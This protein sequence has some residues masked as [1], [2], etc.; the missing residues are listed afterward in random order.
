MSDQANRTDNSALEYVWG[1]YRVYAA[2]SRKQKSKLSK[3][4]AAFLSLTCLGA[5]L[6]GVSQ[7]LTGLHISWLPRVAGGLS[8]VALAIAAYLGREALT[9]DRERHWIR[10]RSAAEA[11]K[12]NAYLYITGTPPYNNGKDADD[13]ILKK[14][15]DLEGKISD[16]TAES[17]D[18]EKKRERIPSCPISVEDYIEKRVKDQI[19]FY[20]RRAAEHDKYLSLWSSIRLILGVISVALGVLIGAGSSKLIGV[21]IAVISTAVSTIVAHLYAGRYSYLVLSYQSASRRLGRLLA[22]WNTS[23]RNQSDKE[24]LI[25]DCEEAISVENSAW[26]AEWID[27]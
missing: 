9:R 17:L 21:W 26:M 2:T 16:L 13:L 11:F 24:Q 20:D 4:R 15:Q 3:W 14:V 10:A 5:V 23:G 7:Q 12:S 6:G 19:G 18:E 8:A 27:K 22:Q 1:L 25:R